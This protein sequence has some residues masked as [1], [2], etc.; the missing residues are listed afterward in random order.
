MADKVS[1]TI[2]GDG[3]CEDSYSVTRN[4]DGTDYFL[5]ITDTAGQEE[6]RGLWAASNLKSDA[7]LMVYDITHQ[8]SL[9]ALDYFM[10]MIDIEA[11]QRLE[12]NQ[13]IM[14]ELGSEARNLQVGM[15]PPVKIIAG[16]K[17]DLKD[18]RAISARDGLEY[19]RKHGCG[20]METSAREIVNIEET[21]ALIVRRVVEAR[22][23]HYQSQQL[24]ARMGSSTARTPALTISERQATDLQ[25]P[26][27]GQRRRG[28]FP[29][30]GGKK[31]ASKRVSFVNT[32]DKE[33]GQQEQQSKNEGEDDES[34]SWWRRLICL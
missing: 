27:D 26:K 15:P 9:E 11:E 21:F 4:I 31:S 2:C 29:L 33:G 23:Q 32:S 8:P 22:R 34:Q 25:Q 1:I 18:A 30:F 14:K 10:D 6:Y 19:A 5:S 13:R 12:D 3:G 7:F 16:N 20:F 24:E 28:G 17:C